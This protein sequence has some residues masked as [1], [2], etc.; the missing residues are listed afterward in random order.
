[1]NTAHDLRTKYKIIKCTD[2]IGLQRTFWKRLFSAFIENTITCVS[3]VWTI[4]KSMPEKIRTA[5]MKY[6]RRCCKITTIDKII[7]KKEEKR[8]KSKENSLMEKN[9]NQIRYQINNDRITNKRGWPR[10][11]YNMEIRVA[12]EKR[13][14]KQCLKQHVHV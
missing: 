5:E 2:I 4:T 14:L 6:W 11:F 10:I 12:M 8:W 3:E 7:D 13:N 9:R 1:M